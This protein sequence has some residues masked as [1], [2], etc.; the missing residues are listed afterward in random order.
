MEKLTKQEEETM[1]YVWQLENC[2]VKD[3]QER[4]PEPKPP[5]TT[6]ASVVKNLQRKRYVKSERVGNSYKY[7][8]IIN[9]SE[10]KRSFM[11]G[12]VHDYFKN[13]FKEMVSFFAKEQKISPEELKDI[14]S[15]IESRE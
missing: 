1:I 9:E 11:S 3:I 2:N 7:S 14:I 13:S 12:F 10:Y 15:E 5:Y 8:P 4:F 6:I